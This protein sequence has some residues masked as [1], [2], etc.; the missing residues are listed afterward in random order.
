MG[1]KGSKRAAKRDVTHKVLLSICTKHQNTN[2]KTI[3]NFPLKW[4]SS[5]SLKKGRQTKTSI[6][7]P[8]VALIL[9]WKLKK[10]KSLKRLIKTAFPLSLPRPSLFSVSYHGGRMCWTT[11]SGGKI[12][13]RRRRRVSLLHGLALRLLYSPSNLY[14]LIPLHF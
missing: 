14:P 7:Y 9:V 4:E 8:H 10:T 5:W 13:R 3:F 2:R 12:D 1:H 11:D 6:F